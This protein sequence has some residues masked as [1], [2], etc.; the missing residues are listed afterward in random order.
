M[1]LPQNIPDPVEST[2]AEP[3]FGEMDRWYMAKDSID[4]GQLLHKA[5]SPESVFGGS[6]VINP[7]L[8]GQMAESGVAI[9]PVPWQYVLFL[10]VLLFL[11]FIIVY[12]YRTSIGI[13]FKSAFSI[14][15][16]IDAYQTRSNDMVAFLRYVTALLMMALAAVLTGIG[17][18]GPLFPIAQTYYIL[19][20]SLVLL[21]AVAIYRVFLIGAIQLMGSEREIYRGLRFLGRISV[22]I[23]TL[24]MVPVVVV[25]GLGDMPLTLTL[26]P[27]GILL[28]YHFGRLLRYFMLSGFSIF[29][30]FLYLCTVEI[31]P[32]S[33]IVALIARSKGIN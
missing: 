14:S 10:L 28:L 31:L 13:L 7:E 32:L 9:T 30:W 24:V 20:G 2:A 6:S 27:S 19:G 21:A 26:I 25:A 12:R 3:I 1:P 5:P 18:Q 22:S 15:K 29:Q 33:F 11:Y 8:V 23:S 17:G 4:L 16:T